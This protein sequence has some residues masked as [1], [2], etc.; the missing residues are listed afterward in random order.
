MHA[1]KDN[2]TS[3]LGI[4]D[5]SNEQLINKYTINYYV[6]DFFKCTALCIMFLFPLYHG[7]SV[8]DSSS[9]GSCAEAL[10]FNAKSLLAIRGALG[11][12]R[13]T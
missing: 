2:G 3:E 13:L 11:F 9:R 12:K 1:L 7:F 5:E 4:D 6:S 8:L 10:T